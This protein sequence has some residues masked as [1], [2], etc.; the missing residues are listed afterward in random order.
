MGTRGSGIRLSWVDLVKLAME[1]NPNK[2]HPFN[3]LGRCCAILH[4]ES[5]RG[6]FEGYQLRPG[7]ALYVVDLYVDQDTEIF[8][9]VVEQKV[10]FGMSL[11]GS[12]IRLWTDELGHEQE[13]A[14]PAGMNVA[15]SY[16][17]YAS[18]LQ[19]KGGQ[20]YK[21]LKLQL[22]KEH[23]PELML[24]CETTLGQALRPILLTCDLP[25]VSA[26]KELS[27]SLQC[28]AHQVI[29]CPF[30]GVA[31][32]LFMEAKALEILACELEEFSDPPS[33]KASLRA[34][35]E[36]ELL[37]D[38]RRILEQEFTDP[39]GLIELA[40]RVGLNDFKLK[41]GFRELFGTTVFGYVRKLRMDMARTLLENGDLT[42]TEV[43]LAAGYSH[44]GYFS[45]AFKKAHGVLPSH[46]RRAGSNG[47]NHSMSHK[48]A[49]RIHQPDGKISTNM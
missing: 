21:L 12:C 17:P 25:K 46:Y 43:A 19:L 26:R 5:M 7:M 29:H 35:R 15:S 2:S 31:R 47:G 33:A 16:Y 40:R 34:A 6:R 23:V 27:P 22:Q 20:T 37:Y 41:R 36:V 28:L 39:P 38:A 32:R 48:S 3:G 4:E 10:G 8:S 18:S 13:I 1:T 11:E 14:V 30:E 44:F 24:G 42:I 49:P 9:H 45:A